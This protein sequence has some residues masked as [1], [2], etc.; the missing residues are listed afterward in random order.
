[1]STIGFDFGTTNSL[2]THILDGRPISY[3]DQGMPIPSVVCYEG[4]KPIVGKEAKERLGEAGLGVYGN[5][6][7]SP[8]SLMHEESIYVDGV[9]RSIVDVVG[10]LIQGIRLQVLATKTCKLQ[11][12]DTAVATIPVTFDGEQRAKLREA[13]TRAGIRIVQYVHEPL[14][15]LYG[16]FRSD[17]G[18]E[19]NLRRFDRQY[20]L[21]FDWGGGTLDLTLCR[22]D[23]GTIFQV[24]NDGTDE[25]GGD[26]FDDALRNE[27]VRVVRSA[28][29]VPNHTSV[30]PD[31]NARLLHRCERA[32]IELSNR[33]RVQVYVDHFFREIENDSLDFKMDRE[34]LEQ[35]TR[36]L[37]DSGTSRIDR[38]LEIARLSHSQIGL[39]LATGGMVNMPAIKSRLHERFG[40]QR[41][42]VPDS[43][44]A[45]I[46]V[47]AAWIAHDKAGLHLAKDVELALARQSYLPLVKANST[48]PMQGEVKQDNFE[49]YCVDPRDGFAK[50]Q[51]VSPPRPGGTARPADPRKILATMTLNVDSNARPFRER[52][53]LDVLVDENLILH[54]TAASVLTGQRDKVE[55]HDLEFCISP[56]TTRSPSGTGAKSDSEMTEEDEPPPAGALSLRPNIAD[57]IDNSL[58]PGELWYEH[59]PQDFDVRLNPPR[60]Q[61][62]ERLYY[63]PC[64]LCGRPSYD[65][66]CTCSIGI[67]H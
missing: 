10:D 28:E 36:P 56:G 12:I 40:P 13:F 2:V 67:M 54:A 3:P 14:A 59:Q 31:A 42:R 5:I 57:K 58:V 62:E 29:G 65:T 63:Q 17:G 43:G 41:V 35:V 47:G 61:V 1:M 44:A 24:A 15:A 27:V 20:V 26:Q 60:V 30:H 25:V 38:L 4:N 48:M 21:V 39:C 11:S 55:I 51:I 9:A 6:V 37:I 22:I 45:A 66:R 18:L 50:F 46:A 34:F 49:L 8:K 33:H 64:V 53:Q 7:R 16:Y 23:N 52:L 19:E 32:K